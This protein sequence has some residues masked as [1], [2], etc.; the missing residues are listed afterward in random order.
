MHRDPAPRAEL[1]RRQPVLREEVPPAREQRRVECALRRPRHQT[2][3]LLGHALVRHAVAVHAEPDLRD[4]ALVPHRSKR[5]NHAALA[6]LPPLSSQHSWS[7]TRG[8]PPPCRPRPTPPPPRPQ[9]AG[10]RVGCW[11]CR[12]G[13]GSAGCARGARQGGRARRRGSGARRPPS[14]RLCRREPAAHEGRRQTDWSPRGRPP[15]C[16]ACQPLCRLGESGAAPRKARRLRRPAAPRTL[17]RRTRAP[18]R[19]RGC[20]ARLRRRWWRSR[21]LGLD[22]R[23]RRR[24]VRLRR[25]RS[26]WRQA[27]C[28]TVRAGAGE[29]RGRERLPSRVY[30]RSSSTSTGVRAQCRWAP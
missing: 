23:E 1:Q 19:T 24:P 15:R 21:C 12:L 7:T 22:R 11:S 16:R 2:R 25:E 3:D 26:K 4:C 9:S 10:R 20:H 8:A 13:R 27:Q 18:Y 17:R 14:S 28:R 5:V 30:S 6:W 29:E